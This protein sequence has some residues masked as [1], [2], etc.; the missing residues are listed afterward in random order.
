MGKSHVFSSPNLI[1]APRRR[2]GG[3]KSERSRM[4]KKNQADSEN[5]LNSL[6]SLCLP[7][8]PLLFL[9]LFPVILSV[10]CSHS[11]LLLCVGESVL[12]EGLFL[13]PRPPAPRVSAPVSCTQISYSKSWKASFSPFSH[14]KEKTELLLFC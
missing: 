10:S 4:G 8:P 11:F 14:F 2:R 1:A 12:I 5:K 7:R 3:G 13:L 6:L 9:S